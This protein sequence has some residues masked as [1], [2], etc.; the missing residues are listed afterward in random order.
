MRGAHEESPARWVDLTARKLGD[1]IRASLPDNQVSSVLT[2]LLIGDQKRIPQELADAYTRA[3]V[4]H[5]LSISGFHVGIIAFFIVQVTLLLASRSEVL[6]LGFNLRRSVL[7][8]AL[9]AML[10]YLYLTGAAPATS[11]SVI[12]LVVF[13]LALYAERETD[14]LNAL[15]LSAMF[16]VALNPPS[17][18]DISFQL[19]FLALWGIV[20]A[21]PPA[22]RRFKDLQPAWLRALTQFVITSC[23]ASA[24]TAIPVLFTF[25]QAS[26]NGIVSNFLIVPL[27][28]YG[29]VLAGFCA[30]PLIPVF[31]PAAQLLLWL[32]GKL[33][34]F[35]NLLVQ[36]FAKLPLL[37]FHGITHL[38]MLLFLA[39]TS[40]FSFLRPSRL[41]LVLCTVLPA[42]AVMGHLLA[43][44]AADGRLRIFMLSMGQAES[45]LIRLPDGGSML[46]DGGGYL[47]DNGRD[48][49]ERYLAPAL[50]KLGVQ[51]IDRMVMTHSHPDHIGGLSYIARTMPV[52]EFWEP[53]SGGSG[54]QYQQLRSILNERHVPRR[55]VAAGDSFS[56]ARGV[57]MKVFSPLRNVSHGTEQLSDDM[58][59]NED[60]LVFRIRFGSFSMLFTADAGFPAEERMIAGGAELA[61]TILKV[62]HHGSRYSTS[63]RFLKLVAPQ[64]ALISAG[65]G[66]AFGLP[67]DDTLHQLRQSGVRVYR[68]DLDGSIELTSDGNGWS[69]S[70]PYRGK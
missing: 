41:R 56:L 12:M 44:S 6:A 50:H 10:L 61:S 19:S 28:G 11:R 62:G 23:A 49:G 64:A 39:C 31:A 29:A 13:V 24:A 35:S 25:N 15:L 17:L 4:N 59:L 5:I 45:L 21:V 48:F 1:F 3:G 66:N 42:L 20:I 47:H 65:Q 68:T 30:L 8:L 18:F 9:P 58:G 63:D 33:V 34:L 52:G 7:L 37:R 27:L 69:I 40:S 51:N 22:M 2:A 16:L 26:L 14:P 57:E 70:T 32:A 60:S 46:V 55:V 38:D 54:D 53:A 67:S 43:P 36:L